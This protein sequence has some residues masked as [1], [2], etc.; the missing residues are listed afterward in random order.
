MYISVMVRAIAKK[1]WETC[2]DFLTFAI[3]RCHYL[4]NETEA[5]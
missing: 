5:P 1:A 4:P 2:V 3:E